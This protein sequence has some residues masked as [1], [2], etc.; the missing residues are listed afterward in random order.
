LSAT[1]LAQRRRVTL[2]SQFPESR[3][4]ELPSARRNASDP[5]AVPF[6]V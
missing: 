6:S 4:I 3:W 5:S 2:E 1:A